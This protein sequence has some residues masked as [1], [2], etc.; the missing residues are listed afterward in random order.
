MSDRRDAT[1]D[2]PGRDGDDAVREQPGADDRVHEPPLPR[3]TPDELRAER[4]EGGETR[5]L[6]GTPETIEPPPDGRGA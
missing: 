3:P 6:P 4:P 2:R 1:D 5:R